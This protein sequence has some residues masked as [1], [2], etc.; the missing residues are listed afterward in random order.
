MPTFDVDVD[1]EI[2][3]ARCGA[4][5]CN[6]GSTGTYKGR[7]RL[8]IEPCKDCIESEVEVM[9]DKMIDEYSYEIDLLKDQIKE[10]ENEINNKE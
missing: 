2:Y 1:F 4:G 9:R 8:D 10:L 5:I 3:C 6:N 7:H